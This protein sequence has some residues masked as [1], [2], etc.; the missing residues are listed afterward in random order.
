[1]N[2]KLPK[3]FL[4]VDALELAQN[5]QHEKQ[6]KSKDQQNQDDPEPKKGAT[7]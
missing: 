7:K 4:N 1:M 3:K 2:E 5:L 6:D